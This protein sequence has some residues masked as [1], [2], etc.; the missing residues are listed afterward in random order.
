MSISWVKSALPPMLGPLPAWVCL[1]IPYVLMSFGIT[2]IVLMLSFLV[3]GAYLTNKGRTLTWTIRR[4]RTSF[5]ANK[6]DARPLGYRR[7]MSMDISIHD[8]D[9]ENWRKL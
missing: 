5:R 2:S 3:L 9:F 1:P 7:A 4:I 8:F 6:M